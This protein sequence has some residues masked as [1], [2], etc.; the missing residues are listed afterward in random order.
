MGK[1]KDGVRV[2][3][4]QILLSLV[5]DSIPFKVKTLT[6]HPL[7]TGCN[8]MQPNAGVNSQPSEYR[9]LAA[10]KSEK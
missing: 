8:L 9:N 1:G 6:K 7:R 5:I 3:P 2:G 4:P 10:S